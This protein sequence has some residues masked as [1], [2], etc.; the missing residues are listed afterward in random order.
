MSTRY[1]TIRSWTGPRFNAEA[2]LSQ[3]PAQNARGHPWHGL[4]YIV[5]RGGHPLTASVSR[6][7]GAIRPHRHQP[8][9]RSTILRSAVVT[10]RGRVGYATEAVTSFRE[11]ESRTK[12]KLAVWHVYTAN[13]DVACLERGAGCV[14]KAL[15]G[16]PS[17]DPSLWSE[18]MK[19]EA[20]GTVD[21]NKRARRRWPSAEWIEG[22]GPIAL[23]AYCRH[24]TVTLWQNSDDA[25]GEK[26]LIDDTGCGGRCGR[27]HEAIDLRKRQSRPR[28]PKTKAAEPKKRHRGGDA[29]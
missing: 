15:E 5:W 17:F 11:G 10:T 14:T 6:A 9:P 3:K 8:D 16:V 28:P 22:D 12:L 27:R 29:V 2:P 21:W 20:V 7:R 23:V 4:G 13:H 18:L 24:L 1:Q 19:K 26:K 25:N